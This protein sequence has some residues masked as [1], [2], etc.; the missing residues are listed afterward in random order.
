MELLVNDDLHDVLQTDVLDSSHPIS[1]DHVDNSD[2]ISELFDTVSY[3]KGSSL[4]GMMNHFL[5]PKTFQ[6]GLKRY[7]TQW[8]FK[9]TVPENLWTAFTEEAHADKRLSED[10]T[11]GEIM[12]TWT[13]QSGFPV[14]HV[15]RNFDGQTAAFTQVF[16]HFKLRILFVMD[17]CAICEL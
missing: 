3:S 15:H 6:N 4:I 17:V 9:N 10:L 8:K 7:L 5:S 11:V 13:T 12:K 14:I 16:K 2:E 1:V